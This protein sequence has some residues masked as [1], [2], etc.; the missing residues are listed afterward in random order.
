MT[1]PGV[2][3]A[4]DPDRAAVEQRRKEREEEYSVYEATQ[5]IPW[6]DVPAYFAGER[7]AKQTVEERGW[8]SLGLVKRIDGADSRSA[9]TTTTTTDETAVSSRP[10]K[11]ANKP[12]WVEYAITQGATREEAEAMTRDDLVAQYQEA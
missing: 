6:G 4:L 8:L 7:V 9:G 3:P 11:S 12:E 1:Y 2:D 5:D 10:T